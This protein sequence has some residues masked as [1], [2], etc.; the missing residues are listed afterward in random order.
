MARPVRLIVA[1]IPKAHAWLTQQMRQAR[2][3][4]LVEVPPPRIGDPYAEGDLDCPLGQ[5]NCRHCGDPTFAA[6][7]RAAGHCEWCGTRHGIAPDAVLAAHGLALEG[8]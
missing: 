6:A 5:P 1:D 8:L 7:C 4:R 2:P 3:G